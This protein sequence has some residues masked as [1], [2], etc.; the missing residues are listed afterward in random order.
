MRGDRELLLES[1]TQ[2]QNKP[3]KKGE[4]QTCRLVTSFLKGRG[5]FDKKET[6]LMSG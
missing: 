1:Q 2:A 3:T 6:N 5:E 4:K